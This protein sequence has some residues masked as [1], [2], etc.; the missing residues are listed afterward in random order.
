MRVMCTDA[1]GSMEEE[2]ALPVM[3][4][5][6]DDGDDHAQGHQQHGEQQVFAEQRQGQRRGRYDLG[7]EQEEHGLRQQ[8]GDAQRDLLL[9]VGR[10]VEH[11]H[12]QVRYAHARHDQVDRVE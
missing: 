6:D 3:Y 5:D 10:Q 12:G 11:Q 4:V 8:Y 1:R 2:S 7:Y 9:G